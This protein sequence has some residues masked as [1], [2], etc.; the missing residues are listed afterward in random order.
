MKS[1]SKIIYIP[2]VFIILNSCAKHNAGIVKQTYHDLTSHYNGY[3]NAK[4]NYNIQIKSLA[5]NRTEDYEQV[6]PLYPFGKIEE[7]KDQ[8]SSLSTS[9]EKARLTIQTHQEKKEGKNYQK[10]EDNSISNWAD[11]AFLLIGKSYYMQGEMDSAISCFKYIT[12]NFDEGVDARSKKKIKKQKSNKKLKA[13]AK[14][15][16][17]KN[18]KKEI[19]G[20]D[21]RPSKKALVHEATRSEALIWLANAYTTNG[22]F[23][24][25]ESV[26]TFIRSDKK[27]LKDFDN[28]VD[29]A[30]AYLFL[31][32]NNNNTSIEYLNKTLESTKKQRNKVRIQFILGQLNEEVGNNEAAA[33]Y[34]KQSIKANSN[35]EMV[36]Y[37][38]LKQI[39]MNRKGEIN[40]KETD[41]LIA[42][43]LRDNKNKEYYDQ[44]YYEKALIALNNNE[45]DEAKEMLA[46]SIE[47]SISN[48]K[49]KGISYITLADLN[50]EEEGYVLAQ[51]YYDSSLALINSDYFD[52]NRVSNRSVVLTDLVDHLTTIKLNDS[53][54]VLAELSPK[55]L[56]S[57][58]YKQAVDLVD[59]E[60]KQENKNK[61]AQLIASGNTS[62]KNDKN[63]WYFYSEASKNSGY[64]KF[65][66]VWGDI[67]LEDDWRRSDKSNSADFDSETAENSKED[68]Y[69]ERVD[70]KYQTM[71]SAVPNTEEDKK[72]FRD[73][74]IT[75]Y[76]NAA[77]TYKIGLDNLPKSVE[78]FETL[79]KKY[80]SNVYKPE[81]LYQLYV[82]YTDLNKTNKAS[83]SKTELVN[84]Y[85]DS[86]FASYIRDPRTLQQIDIKTE[87]ENY[88]D[89]TYQKY[90]DEKFDEVILTCSEIDS[91]F[92]ENHIKAKFDLLKA[93]AI[94]GKKLKEPFIA[95][96]EYVIKTYQ[97]TEEQEKASEL[98]AYLNG[99][100]PNSNTGSKN[101]L[102]PLNNK[103]IDIQNL[104]N[105]NTSV[106]DASVKE[107]IG[108][109]DDK[110]GGLKFKLGS[111]EIN[112]GGKK[113]NNKELKKG[114]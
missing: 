71:L 86:K 9:I 111:K 100:E 40:T 8:N 96:L 79:N 73:D 70:L 92:T 29:K 11:D 38:K 58:L 72:I 110:D 18:L 102:K 104:K 28:E 25:A 23:T 85:P 42:K 4:E 34:Y 66:Q 93:M 15:L 53:L 108:T 19:D 69:F 63:S 67:E 55:E 37:A 39:Q 35:F 56:E 87:V 12:A 47:K 84:K 75:A 26:I 6:L 44:L 88:Y 62:G 114:E 113:S 61:Q 5:N 78:M 36:F 98:L 60:I 41:K 1:I 10:G 17:D 13:K 80:P 83:D 22:Q 81:A 105:S 51:A 49:Q 46:K 2:L 27:F 14:K 45:R 24:D 21:I 3:F 95:S 7:I 64:K 91:K 103:N 50:Y 112:V 65:K 16:E 107:K 20:K 106:K 89:L 76:Y 74:I 57:F 54:L 68:E 97:N 82:I 90:L 30:N 48:S 101:N 94:G 32:Q 52:Y 77:V 43:L 59:A 99:E 109:E 33:E 31:S